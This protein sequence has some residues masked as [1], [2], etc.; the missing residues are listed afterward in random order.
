MPPRASTAARTR[1]AK[2]AASIGSSANVQTRARICDA[3]ENAARLKALHHLQGLLDEVEGRAEKLAECFEIALE[4][5][6]LIRRVDEMM[7]DQ[8]HRRVGEGK[9]ELVGQMV[10]QR[11]LFRDIGF[12][13]WCVI[14]VE[15]RALA[16]RGP[17]RLLQRARA[18]AFAVGKGVLRLGI[19]ILFSRATVVG[20]KV[21]PFALLAA[22]GLAFARVGRVSGMAVRL[23]LGFGE[24]AHSLRS[25]ALRGGSGVLGFLAFEQRI[26]LKLGLDECGQLHVGELQQLDR[27]LQLRRH[28][29]TVALPQLKLCGEGHT[30]SQAGSPDGSP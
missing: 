13:V 20:L 26:A 4:V 18:V 15:A 10:L 11:P 27:L 9:R 2:N 6:G 12:E 29:Q 22:G 14:A 1:R 21:E 7:A 25:V 3:G 16:E 19:E 8:P 24:E 17:A 30:H 28:H 23:L 5:T